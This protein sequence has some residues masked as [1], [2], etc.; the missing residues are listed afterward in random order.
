[1]GWA[2]A[3]HAKDLYRV[4][5]LKVLLLRLAMKLAKNGAECKT[6]MVGDAVAID[7]LMAEHGV[8]HPVHLF[9]F[10]MV[11]MIGARKK[12][13]ALLLRCQNN[14][15]VIPFVRSGAHISIINNY[16]D[17]P[18]VVMEFAL[19][20]ILLSFIWIGYV[21][22]QRTYNHYTTPFLKCNVSEGYVVSFGPGIDA[23]LAQMSRKTRFNIKYYSKKLMNSFPAVTVEYL[24]LNTLTRDL[25]MEYIELVGRRYD[26]LYWEGF[27]ESG[28]FERFRENVICT[29]VRNDGVAI[30]FNIFFRSNDSLVFT[31]NTFDEDYSEYSLGFLTTFFSIENAFKGG[32]RK[33]IL[34]PGDYGYKSRLS[35]HKELLYEYSV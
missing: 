18:E 26:K 31:G 28:T 11:R 29:V 21:V 2:L 7:K 23:Y 22:T 35:T 9:E 1:M 16:M 25:F 13:C 24:G 14:E 4:V 8:K 6:T 3:K 19:K 10:T 17:I 15:Y 32:I 12:K 30:A 34:G 27:L 5:A 33:I 20:A